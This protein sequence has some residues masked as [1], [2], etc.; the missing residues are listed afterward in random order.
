MPTGYTYK[1]EDGTMTSARDFL[2]EY[3]KRFGIGYFV[4]QQGELPMPTEYSPDLAEKAISDYHT[5]ELENAKNRF[6]IFNAL[7]EQELKRKYDSYVSDKLE[8]NKKRT[9]E[10]ILKIQRYLDMIN[11]VNKW[12]APS[13]L[14]E[15][16]TSAIEHLEKSKEFDCKLYLD[17][18]STYDEWLEAQ[19]E[20]YAWHINYHTKKKAAED[21]RR[22]EMDTLLKEFYQS[23]E[24][25]E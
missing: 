19:R 21:K 1:V 24:N 7:S 22:V 13:E 8:E 25:L 3:T 14:A 6:K 20:D 10:N 11:K 4:T 16:K 23:L 9:E 17:T 15:M 12:N 5:R 18:I 2:I